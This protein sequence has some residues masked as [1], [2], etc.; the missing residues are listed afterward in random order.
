MSTVT[1][2]ELI[3]VIQEALVDADARDGGP[4]HG[5]PAAVDRCLDRLGVEQVPL[6]VLTHPHADHVDGLPGVLDGRRVG[7][8][9]RTPVAY[10]EPRRVGAV[11][12]QAVWPAPGQ[13]AEDVN[14][15]SVVLMAEVSGARLLLTGDIEPPAQARLAR[16]LPGLQVDVVKVPHH[17]SRFQDVDWLRS[18]GARIALVSVGE[19]NDYGHPA[20]E[21]LEPLAD[22]GAA[23][24]RTDQEGDLAVV[25]ADG[26]LSVGSG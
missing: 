2:E 9:E 15:A 26:R 8:V 4:L 17:G 6:V 21:A 7:T 13:V 18:L 25:V 12:L 22:T 5:E 11:T 24:H 1:V 20:A 23:V 3:E 10:G 14:D 16:L 19:D